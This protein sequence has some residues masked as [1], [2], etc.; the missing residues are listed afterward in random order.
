MARCRPCRW[1]AMSRVEAHLL[2]AIITNKAYPLV[3]QTR[4]TRITTINIS[5]T[6]HNVTNHRPTRNPGNPRQFPNCQR[7]RINPGSINSR[8]A[9]RLCPRIN[10]IKLSWRRP[11]RWL[12]I[13]KHRK[14]STCS[15]LC[16]GVAHRYLSR[17]CSMPIECEVKHHI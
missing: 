7:R 1:E 9:L 6:K 15:D 16:R 10:P 5:S 14:L 11:M 17:N 13:S 12:A 4:I 2:L 3:R 8:R